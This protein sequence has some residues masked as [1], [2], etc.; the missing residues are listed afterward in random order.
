[1][2]DSD[3]I[4]I[5][6]NTTWTTGDAESGTVRVYLIHG[7]SSKSGTT[8][9]QFGG[10]TDVEVRIFSRRGLE[11]DERARA[12]ER[13]DIERL[14][15]SKNVRKTIEDGIG[16]VAETAQQISDDTIPNAGLGIMKKMKEVLSP[17]DPITVFAMSP[18][19]PRKGGFSDEAERRIAK[20]QKD[21]RVEKG[22]QLGLFTN[23]GD[24]FLYE[25]YKAQI[26]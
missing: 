5:N 2:S 1:M 3:G 10:G 4:A 24:E 25:K 8:R 6:I 15:K 7:P 26:R 18:E 9:A 22:D 23:E 16:K 13:Q 17:D 12:I 14:A 19:I 20:I 11:K 21:L